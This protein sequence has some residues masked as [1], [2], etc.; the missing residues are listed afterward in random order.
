[1]SSLSSQERE[2]YQ[3]HISLE[4]IGESGQM[5]LKMA[6]VLVVGAG[7]LGCPALQYLAGAGIGRIGIVDDDRVEKSN[8]QRQTLF[9]YDDIGHHKAD[10]AA[11]K[12]SQKNPHLKNGRIG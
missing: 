8:L 6:S 3:R 10:V 12:L 4:E 9:D 7:G 11:A 1:M 5:K 2:H